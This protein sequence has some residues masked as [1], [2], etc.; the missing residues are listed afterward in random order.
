MLIGVNPNPLPSAGC[1]ALRHG[2]TSQRPSTSL[3]DF[4]QVSYFN[5]NIRGDS[6]A[7]ADKYSRYHFGDGC[8]LS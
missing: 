3:G 4:D 5:L 6:W 2:D 7:E 1:V 8:C